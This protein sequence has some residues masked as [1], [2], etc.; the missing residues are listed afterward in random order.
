[1]VGYLVMAAWFAIF[2]ALQR[3]KRFPDLAMIP[4]H[5]SKA[6]C[7]DGAAKDEVPQQPWQRD[8]KE[9]MDS[10]STVAGGMRGPGEP[11]HQQAIENIDTVEEMELGKAAAAAARNQSG[12]LSMQVC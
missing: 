3:S 4:I 12:K 9:A 11:Q 1:M 2:Y 7:D 8:F 6:S 10:F 5:P